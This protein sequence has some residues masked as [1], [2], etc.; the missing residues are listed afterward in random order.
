MRRLLIFGALIILLFGGCRTKKPAVET[1]SAG[2]QPKNEYPGAKYSEPSTW[3]LGYFNPSQLSMPP[4]S[5]WFTKGYDEYQP[6]RN[7]M[8][9]LMLLDKNDL[10]ILIVM[11]TWCPDSRREVPRFMRVLYQ[12]KFPV[13]NVTFI[14]VD[15][16]KVA[17]IGDYDKFNIQR[18]PTF[19]FLKNKVEAGRIIENPVTSLE[20]DMLNILNRNENN[21]NQ[22]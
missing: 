14:G 5:E 12:L 22:E 19:I 21:K 7:V 9:K 20:Q 6:D 17:P 10:T 3:L 1:F 13:E 8:E 2:V 18:V 15:N 16:S 4:H 11:G